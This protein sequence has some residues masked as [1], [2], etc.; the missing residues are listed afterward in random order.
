[1]KNL[2]EEEKAPLCFNAYSGGE[3][4]R[5]EKGVGEDREGGERASKGCSPLHSGY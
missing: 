3:Y 4:G 2:N 5:A 1:M